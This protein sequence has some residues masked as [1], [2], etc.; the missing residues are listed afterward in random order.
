M[1]TTNLKVILNLV[2]KVKSTST[3]R[4]NDKGEQTEFSNTTNTKYS[5]TTKVTKS[6]YDTH[7]D[8]GNWTQRTEYDDKGKATKITK[9][10]YTYRKEEAKK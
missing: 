1:L 5:T 10:V 6:T 7:D 2:G 3:A 4:Y 9:R 8:K